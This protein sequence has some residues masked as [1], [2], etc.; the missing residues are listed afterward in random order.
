MIQLQKIYETNFL[1]AFQ[2]RL[3]ESQEKFVSSPVRSLAQAIDYIRT[4]PLGDCNRVALTC[5]KE[6]EIARKL[7]E[8]KGF[9][10]TGVK[11]GDEIEL[12]LTL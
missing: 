11:D 6:N 9:A 10:T 1:D 12:V 3:E 7:Y 2:L 8:R 5:N 4:K